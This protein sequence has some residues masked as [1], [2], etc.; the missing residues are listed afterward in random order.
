MTEFD[1]SALVREV[2]DSTDLTDH[3]QV[4]KEVRSRIPDGHLE[5]ALI[6]ALTAYVRVHFSLYRTPVKYPKPSSKSAK[7][8]A[9]R[10][11]WQRQLNQRYASADGTQ[12]LLRDFTAADCQFQADLLRR[13]AAENMAKAEQWDHLA[14]QVGDGTVGELS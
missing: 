4:A 13:K 14:S 11:W 12:K 9:I 2:H 7:R 8:D 3:E 6:E 5:A 1:L 10:A